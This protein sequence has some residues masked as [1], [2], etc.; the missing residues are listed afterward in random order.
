MLL[1]I[2]T[3]SVA[4]PSS[5]NTMEIEQ[6]QSMDEELVNLIKKL[7]SQIVGWEWIPETLKGPLPAMLFLYTVSREG[8]LFGLFPSIELTV[9]DH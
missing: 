9:S 4:I 7:N 8:I 6:K 1:L 2:M 3:A 5:P